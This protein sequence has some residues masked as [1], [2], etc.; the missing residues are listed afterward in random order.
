MFEPSPDPKTRGRQYDR[1]L[2]H[3]ETLSLAEL[4]R[5]VDDLLTRTGEEPAKPQE[6]DGEPLDDEGVE[7]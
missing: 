4:T 1:L 3:L 2:R 7:P 6:P 5:L